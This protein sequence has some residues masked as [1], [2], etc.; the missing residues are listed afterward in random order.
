MS[1][2]RAQHILQADEESANELLILSR[3]SP[4]HFF[5]YFALYT[6]IQEKTLK[7]LP[8]D[9]SEQV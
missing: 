4:L 6:M 2:G 5:L 1:K 8:G 7:S 3:A 9:P